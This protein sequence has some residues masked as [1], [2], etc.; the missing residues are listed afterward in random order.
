MAH[1]LAVSFWNSFSATGL[2][3]GTLFF[4]ASLTPSL[5]P[6][7]FTTQGILSG[8]ALAAG[9]GIGVFGRWLA[10]YMELPEP[11]ERFLQ[12]AK[13]LSA[14]ICSAI[15][16]AFLWQ[17][18]EWQNSIR[19]LM[20]LEM[21]DSVHP[22]RTGLIAAVTFILLL[23]AARLFRLVLGIISGR[24]RHFVPRRV[25][26][27]IGVFAAVALFWVAIEGVLFRYALRAADASFQAYNE[28]I[29]PDTEPPA[30]PYKTGSAASLISWADLGRAGREFIASGPTAQDLEHFGGGEAL[31]PIRVYVGLNAAE[32]VE[33]RAALA[34]AELQRTDAF[35][36]SVL[37][38][39]M[40]TGTGWVDP[41]AMDTLEYLHRGDV[42]SVTVQ[43]SYLTS[44]LSLLVEPDYGT[45]TAQALFSAVYEH[46]RALP[47]N[48]RPRL[49]LHGLSLGALASESSTELF[50]ILDDPF[51]GALWSGPPFASRIWSYVTRQRE[52]DSPPWLPRFGGGSFVRFTNQSNALD[53]PGATW[54]PIRI[55]YL[56][57]ASDPV[58]F[59][60]YHALYRRPDWMNEPRGPDVSPDLRWYPVISALQ[61][62]LDMALATTAPM[63]HGHV[64]APEHYI[65]AWVEVT[66]VADLSDAEIER[67]KQ[68]FSMK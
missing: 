28:L 36:R 27:V 47:E 24:L 10:H 18:A 48:S 4:A 38:V 65:D 25:A 64:Y 7:T 33:E 3:V 14:L 12:I 34:L 17:A 51:Q 21:L 22:M 49:Y 26:N 59:F 5:L 58:T 37:V 56:Q 15:A 67:L 52:P 2:Y 19:R 50:E 68:F 46:W 55:V 45:Q 43:Y 60:D 23:A 16:L 9:Y 39:V 44:W 57:Y 1:R 54:G 35:E 30:D 13:Y 11:K 61:L 6:R 63:G 8:V 32:T 29:Q 66:E 40:P 20:G 41:A 42:A 62:L 53:I 31:A